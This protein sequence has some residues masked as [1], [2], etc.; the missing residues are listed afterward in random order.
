MK[1]SASSRSTQTTGSRRA[2]CSISTTSTPRLKNSTPGTS[3]AKRPP[4]RDTW[5]V[6]QGFTPGST[7]TNF[8]Q[9]PR[10]GSYVD[11]RPLVTIE[12]ND[13]SAS[14][15][16]HL[17]SRA[18]HQH[19]HRG[20]ASARA[21]SELLSPL[22]CTGTSQEGF[23]AEWRMIRPVH[24]RRRPH[25][26]LR[27]LRRGRPGRRAGEVRRTRAADAFIWERRDP[28]LGTRDRRVQ[29]PRRGRAPCARQPGESI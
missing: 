28:S 1:C 26:P 12:A 19:L 10:I 17:G 25:Q 16:C 18:G 5:S 15:A 27:D 2:S 6:T 29:P 13:L 20:C 8:P 9:R 22:R 7:G 24:G 4:T 23:D 11:H 21:T 3:P 14:H